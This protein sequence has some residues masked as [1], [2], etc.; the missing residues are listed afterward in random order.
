MISTK[1][2]IAMG[3]FKITSKFIHAMY[4]CENKI[5]ISYLAGV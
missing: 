5:N 4:V 2:P 3:D 1:C